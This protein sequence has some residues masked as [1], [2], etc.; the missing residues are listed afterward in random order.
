[1]RDMCLCGGERGLP[2]LFKNIIIPLLDDI[3]ISHPHYKEFF[4]ILSRFAA[5]ATDAIREYTKVQNNVS[6]FC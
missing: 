2:L 6:I 4:D 3:P 5:M 1:M